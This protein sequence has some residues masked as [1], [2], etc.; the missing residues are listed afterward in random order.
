MAK[1]ISNVV[2]LAVVVAMCVVPQCSAFK[3]II[4]AGKT[5]CISESVEAQHFQMEGNPRI[6]GALFVGGSSPSFQP[7]VTVRVV[8][9]A[10]EQMW[11]QRHVQDEVHF[12][13]HA[14]GP[15]VYKVCLFNNWESRTDAIVDLVYFTLAHIRRPGGPVNV[16][17]G[18]SEAR[19]KQVAN[20]EHVDTLRHGIWGLSEMLEI[21]QGEQKYLQRKLERHMKTSRS[22]NWRALFYTSLETLL[23]VGGCGANVYYIT[24]QFKNAGRRISV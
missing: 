5:E 18:T 13:I 11:Q 20:K 19:G 3:V 7:M 10:G 23:V 15:G 4:P 14:K 2:A 17:Q 22:N 1:M 16:P 8:S 21:L 6:E 9:P 12:N 24:R